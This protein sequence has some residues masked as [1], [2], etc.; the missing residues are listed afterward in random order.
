MKE[1][2][3]G[4]LEAVEIVYGLSKFYGA[5]AIKELESFIDKDPQ[6]LVY[7]SARAPE[8]LPQAISDKYLI[9][10]KA[11]A[12]L[13]DLVRL[14]NKVTPQPEIP[15]LSD[16]RD[17]EVLDDLYFIDPELENFDE[18]FKDT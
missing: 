9:F 8:L 10:G 1:E 14:L 16:N 11:S 6:K 17:E 13:K 3:F 5:E 18:H 2:G 7:T 4:H 15:V 12:I